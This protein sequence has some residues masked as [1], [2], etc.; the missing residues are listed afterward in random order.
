MEAVGCDRVRKTLTELNVNKVSR[1]AFAS[2]RRVQKYIREFAKIQ[3][4]I[5]KIDLRSRHSNVLAF[6]SCQSAF[7]FEIDV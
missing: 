2:S 5:F 1:E 7:G 6:V 4:S 3:F